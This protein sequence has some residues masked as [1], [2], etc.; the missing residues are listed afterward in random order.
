MLEPDEEPEDLLGDDWENYDFADLYE[1]DTELGKRYNE[2]V[3]HW[4]YD[5]V[6][7]WEPDW[8]GC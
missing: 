4:F 3:D 2:A 8:E 6:I 5:N 1:Q 7:C